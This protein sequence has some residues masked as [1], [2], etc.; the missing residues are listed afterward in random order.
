VRS[1]LADKLNQL[2]LGVLLCAWFLALIARGTIFAS[3]GIGAW[4]CVVVFWIV[5]AILFTLSVQRL[6]RQSEQEKLKYVL[7]IIGIAAFM[8]RIV[9]ST[10]II[11]ELSIA[12]WL[13]CGVALVVLYLR[14][15]ATS[16]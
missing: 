9:V 1:Q 5:T 8:H 11:A 3:G 7:V 4:V 16:V 12:V 15:I 10:G 2:N 14:R 13:I 6:S